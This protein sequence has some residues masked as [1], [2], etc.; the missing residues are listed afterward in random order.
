MSKVAILMNNIEQQYE[1]LRTSLGL[2][3]QEKQIQIFVIR[4]SIESI[5]NYF[6]KN[7]ELLISASVRC[8]SDNP[9]NV[10]KFGFEYLSTAEIGDKLKNADLVIPF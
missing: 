4:H 8:F 1:G 9:I 10:E 7:R 2:I 5:G 3:G 6:S